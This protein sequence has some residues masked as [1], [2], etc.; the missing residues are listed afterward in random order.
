[1]MKKENIT[2]AAMKVSF[3]FIKIVVVHEKAILICPVSQFSHLLGL[4]DL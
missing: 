1:M 2:T 3:G 4:I